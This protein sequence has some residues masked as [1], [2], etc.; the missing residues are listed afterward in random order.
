MRA[1]LQIPELLLMAHTDD[2]SDKALDIFPTLSSFACMFK[3]GNNYLPTS[4]IC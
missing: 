2:A 1:R 3:E 4:V